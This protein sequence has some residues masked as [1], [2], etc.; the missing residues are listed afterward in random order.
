MSKSG[1]IGHA[2]KLF[3]QIPE[4]KSVFFWN[5]MIKC[6]SRTRTE[7]SKTWDFNIFKHVEIWM[8][9]NG[10]VP[11]SVTSVSLLSSC[12]KLRDLEAGEA[13][14][15]AYRKFGLTRDVFSWTSIVSEFTNMGD[16]DVAAFVLFR[17]MQASNIRPD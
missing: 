9:K 13:D 12:S 15:Q 17:Q 16:I 8:E 4:P 2:L 10:V 7:L 14:S 6:Y 3:D 1:D 11:S 5:T